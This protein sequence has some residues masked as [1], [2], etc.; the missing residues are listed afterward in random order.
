MMRRAWIFG[1]L[2]ATCAAAI[3][4]DAKQRQLGQVVLDGV[5]EVDAAVRERAMQ[6]FEVRPTALGDVH[7]DGRSILIRTRFGNTNQVHLVTQPMGMRKQIT[8][9]DEPVGGGWFMRGSGGRH[10]L[11]S[12]D[13]GGD[14]K[15][16]YYRLDLDSGRTACLTDGTSRHGGVSFSRCGRWMV[17]SSTA[18]NER[19]FDLYRTDLQAA[20]AQT[21]AIPAD[22][23]KMIWQVEGQYYPGG[24]SPDGSRLLV[25]RFLSERQTEWF[26]VNPAGENG[27]AERLPL[28]GLD[29]QYYYGGGTWSADGKSVFIYSDRDGEFRKLYRVDLDYGRWIC[30][31]PHLTW[32]V[33]DIAVDETGRG[34]AFVTNE[35][36]ISRLHFADADGSNIRGVGGLP[37]GVIGGMSFNEQG[38]VLGLT[39]NTSTSPSDV[40]LVSFPD[41]AATRWTESEVGGLNPSTFVEPS[42]IRYPSFDQGPDGQPRQIPAFYYRG[43]GEGKRPVVIFCHGGPES[44]T[45]PTFSSLFQLWVNELG[46]SVLAPNVRGST[47]YGRSFHELDNGVKREDSVKDVGALLDWIE[48]QPELDASRVGIFGGSYGGYMVLGSLTNYPERFRAAI[49]IVGITSFVTFLET[50]PEFRRDL[51]RAEYG[52]ERV[53][54]VRAVLERISPL[55]NAEKIRAALFVAHGKNDPRVPY[56][57]AEQI[58]S[59][60]RTLGRPVWYALALNEGHGF[61]KKDNRDL[62]QVLYTQFWK[63]HLVGK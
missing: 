5:P 63:E 12:K 41:G 60:V 1:V 3:A 19:D 42:L 48:K 11:F 7:P 57:E 37:N 21:G 31:T 10:V 51:R 49:D 35:D 43:R 26:I 13:R 58:V 16:Q 32:D 2:A 20:D 9:F 50:T 24:F 40:Y 44:Q 54:E 30:L 8:F 34:M 45:L 61:A 53:P 59:K 38:G 27:E 39:I 25:M 33:E 6:Y 23:R 18:R 4:Q 52:D 15:N 46:V 47:G 22:A 17:S 14:E 36:G 28:P 29:P 56:T 55:N 62:M